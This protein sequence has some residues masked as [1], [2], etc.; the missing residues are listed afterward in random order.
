MAVTAGLPNHMV[1]LLRESGMG[2]RWA[3]AVPALIGLAQVSGRLLLFF[4]ERNFN[5][6]T[7]N[8]IIPA[9]IQLALMAILAA[10]LAKSSESFS[11]GQLPLILVGLFV[12]LWG[13]GNGMLTIVKGT[14]VAQYVS[15]DHVASLNGV[16]GL[17]LAVARAGAP[18]ALG[19]MWNTQTGYQNGLALLL[20]LGILGTAAL[21]MAQRITHP[22]SD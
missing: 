19:L 13:I 12:L 1:T 5:V 6:H 18:M 10:L 11:A 9:L 3:I 15:R 21:A 20:G 2:E 17:P 14:A 7:A 22:R 4:F 8:R 16:L